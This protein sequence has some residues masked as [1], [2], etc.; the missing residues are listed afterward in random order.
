MGTRK[1]IRGCNDNC[2]IS[3]VSIYYYY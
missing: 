3:K 1:T 2:N